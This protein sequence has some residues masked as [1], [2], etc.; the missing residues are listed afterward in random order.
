[1][2]GVGGA[3][4]A[5]K[6]AA[7]PAAQQPT[8]PRARIDPPTHHPCAPAVRSP[9]VRRHVRVHGEHRIQQGGA[10]AAASGPHRGR[11]VTR[12]RVCFPPPPFSPPSLFCPSVHQQALQCTNSSVT[13]LY[14]SPRPPPPLPIV[15]FRL[16]FFC[17]AAQVATLRAQ[18]SAITH[19]ACTHARTHARTHSLTHARTHAPTHPPTHSPTHP[20]TVTSEPQAAPAAGRQAGTR[21]GRPPPPQQHPPLPL[22]RAVAAA[23]R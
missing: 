18:P 10:G 6:Q 20:R 14:S 22:P 16:R 3:S 8:H 5:L 4:S 21:A 13:T 9:A 19:Q 1:M 15:L 11:V 17:G 2:G 7:A 12:C 23:A